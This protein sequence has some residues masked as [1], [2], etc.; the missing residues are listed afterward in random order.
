MAPSLVSMLPSQESE[1]WRQ[2][3]S[4]FESAWAWREAQ[5]RLSELVDPGATQRLNRKISQLSKKERHLL[6]EMAANLAWIRMFEVLNTEE[7]QALAAWA[8]AIK[9][10]G[11]G[12]GKYAERHRRTAR[13]Y[14]GQARS[15]IPAWIMPMYRVAENVDA[16]PEL[17]DV[18]IVDEASQSSVESLFLFYLGRQVVV[19]GDDQQ[20]APEAVGIDQTTVHR[21]QDQYLDGLPFSE[22]FSPE[23]SLFDQAN[24]RFP[25]R[26][27]LREH[28]RCMPEI[29]QF[30]NEISYRQK[31]LIPLRQYGSDRLEPIRTVYL[32]HGYR[33]GRRSAINRPEAE[34]IVAR[35]E[36]ICADPR[37]DDKTIGVISL[38]GSH[39][40][41][42]VEQMLFD[43][44]GPQEMLARQIVCGDA[45]AFQGDERD[46]ILLSMVAAPNT[47]IGP[48]AKETDKR[49]FNVAA[50]RA[51]D[52]VWLIHS[53]TPDDLSASDM[54]RRLLKYYLDP[55]VSRLDEIGEIDPDVL[56][57][58]FESRFEQ[59]VYSLIRQKDF[60]VIPQVPV[61][62]Y[63]IDLVV[64]GM[65]GRIAVECDGDKW[66]GPDRWEADMAR[67]R[68]LERAGWVFFRVA[69]SEFYA[70]PDA[71]LEP[72]WILLDRHG[73]HPR[74]DSFATSISTW[75][76]PLT[77]PDQSLAPSDD[78][79]ADRRSE[80]AVDVE[81]PHVPTTSVALPGGAE[82][83][84]SSSPS[85][86]GSD[87]ALDKPVGDHSLSLRVGDRLQHPWKGAATVVNVRFPESAGETA[88][89]IQFDDGGEFEYSE[90]E[91][92]QAGFVRA[93]L[94][95][96]AAALERHD[97]QASD[98][99]DRHSYEALVRE[100][101][102]L[103]RSRTA[104][105]E[106]PRVHT[107]WTPTEMPDPRDTDTVVMARHMK[108]VVEAEGP[109]TADRIYKLVIM[110]AG[111]S[112]VTKPVRGRL[113]RASFAMDGVDLHELRNPQT[114][115]PQRVARLHGTPEVVVRELGERDFYEVPL[116]EI[117]ALMEDLTGGRPRRSVEV[118]K[119][120]VL[121]AYGGRKLT[122]KADQYLEAALELLGDE[123][124]NV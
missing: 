19:V 89:E 39:Q 79:H 8:V 81:G 18:V 45:Y 50:S 6:A 58:P 102:S 80:A 114:N 95:G 10:V 1:E 64:E 47:R 94:D 31:S 24:V 87:D 70:D 38:Q 26:I 36:K 52:Q 9:R 100:E 16:L 61:A 25:G 13:K 115:W 116:D 112:R 43:R 124:P 106:P 28:F 104:S 44:I 54:R 30:S 14:M 90:D 69:G 2:R 33:E 111:F 98:D 96:E 83:A 41:H 74:V 21:L 99:V 3:F 71:A 17:F 117:A 56:N 122:K 55:K 12:K 4:T 11:K 97:V 34:E 46:I 77:G 7:S 72:L 66:H 40:S 57:A 67:Q 15:A 88:V 84:V 78:E 42:L 119:R 108:S 62:G 105:G 113:N 73:I 63:R 107:A 110:A 49:R 92:R 93:E 22:L 120:R 85:D 35:I 82:R 37:Y 118:T 65:Q 86:Q 53:V 23:S 68:Q 91:Y 76:D 20:I 60:R 109:V 59:D 27:V 121:D 32:E 123:S 29:I 5:T 101:T 103:P 75:V 48:L 51:K